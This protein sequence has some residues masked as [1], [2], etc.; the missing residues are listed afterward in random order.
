MPFD[1]GS[2]NA[3]IM[4]CTLIDWDEMI[5]QAGREARNSSLGFPS[6]SATEC[7]LSLFNVAAAN[8]VFFFTSSSSSFHATITRWLT[9][10]SPLEVTCRWENVWKAP[11]P[12]LH[13]VG[14]PMA[15][16]FCF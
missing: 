12:L 4:L 14:T 9:Q 11:P 8:T 16:A 15:A 13:R 10:I 5:G 7:S 2:L 1:D 3:P 6:L